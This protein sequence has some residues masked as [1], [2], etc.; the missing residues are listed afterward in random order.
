MPES[1]VRDELAVVSYPH[2]CSGEC[3]LGNARLQNAE[4]ALKLS[5]LIAGGV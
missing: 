3:A 1:F 2:G 4:G 5:V